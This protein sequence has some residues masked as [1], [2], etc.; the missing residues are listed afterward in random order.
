MAANN[1]ATLGPN[2]WNNNLAAQQYESSNSKYN[3]S[4][5]CIVTLGPKL[6]LKVDLSSCKSQGPKSIGNAGTEVKVHLT[7]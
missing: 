6:E 3:D 2:P 1:I 4:N 7:N 5:A